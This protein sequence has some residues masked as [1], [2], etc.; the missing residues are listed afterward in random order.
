MATNTKAASREMPL[1]TRQAEYSFD[2]PTGVGGLQVLGNQIL[3]QI[4]A[5]LPA[6]L[7]GS[8][9]RMLRCLLTECSKTPALLNCAP[10]TLLGAVIQA[11]QL[12]LEIGGPAGQAYLIPFK[13]SAT[14]LVGYKGFITLAHRS[15]RVKRITPRVVRQ[16]DRF[17]LRYGTDQELY[18]E[19]VEPYDGPPVGYYAVVELVN[20]GK[21]FEF[22]TLKQVQ[23]H[24]A[25]FALSK[26]GGP[27]ASNFDEMA[28]K[29]C[30]RKLAKRIP[31]SAEMVSAVDLDE[32]A[33]GDGGQR[34]EAM[35]SPGAGEPMDDVDGMQ[36][37]LAEATSPPQ[38]HIPG[39]DDP[40]ND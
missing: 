27:W 20:G 29:T 23:D 25:R 22:M 7:K 37:R 12:G 11:A 32:Q 18:H 38:G 14:L 24:K 1:A 26:N 2:R 6:L 4:K 9:D 36:Q 17:Q 13:G 34:L 40:A 21:D 19:P 8:A 10:K 35:F 3:P 16:G 31:L 28:M 39:V 5:A 30:I 15:E 33:D